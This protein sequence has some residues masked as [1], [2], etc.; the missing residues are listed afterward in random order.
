MKKI[1]F[2]PRSSQ[3]D[4]DTSKATNSSILVNQIVNKH[5]RDWSDASNKDIDG[6]TND[7]MNLSIEVDFLA[8]FQG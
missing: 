1:H 5:F 8:N 6:T 7:D 3:S 4:S 2:H